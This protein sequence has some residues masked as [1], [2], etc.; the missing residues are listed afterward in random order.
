[1]PNI[2]QRMNYDFVLISGGGSEGHIRII[3][4]ATEPVIADCRQFVELSSPVLGVESP[5]RECGYREEVSRR[6]KM[7]SILGTYPNRS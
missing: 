6:N 2:L 5:M 7:E 1:M 3:A 4:I